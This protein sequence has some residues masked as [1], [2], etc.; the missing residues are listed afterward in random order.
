MNSILKTLSIVTILFIYCVP[1][2][3][4]EEP[5]PYTSNTGIYSD[6]EKVGYSRISIKE[7][8]GLTLVRESTELNIKLLDK[9]QRVKTEAEYILSGYAL[10][11]FKFTMSSDAGDLSAVGIADKGELRIKIKSLSGVTDITLPTE[12]EFTIFALLPRWLADRPMSVGGEYTVPLFDPAAALMGIEAGDLVSTHK[13]AARETVEIPALGSVDTYRV[14]SSFL[15]SRYTSWITP[16]GEVIKQT[17]PPGLTAFKEAGED[18]GGGKYASFDIMRKTSIPSEVKLDNPRGLKYLKAE[19][20]VRGERDHGLTDLSDGYRQYSKDD[21]V[22]IKP[23]DLDDINSYTLPYEDDLFSEYISPTY[24]IQS[25]D[26]LIKKKAGDIVKGETD[27]IKA[28]SRINTWVYKN[29]KKE[30]TVSLPNA[31]DVLQSRAGD[32]NEHAAL[33]AALA[34]ASGIPT[35]LAVGTIYIDGRFYYHAWNEVFVGQWIA[36]DPTYG[37]MPADATH[38]K[39][40]EGDLKN[41]KDIMKLV[42]KLNIKVLDAS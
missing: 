14:E 31:R 13:V 12:E 4:G 6:G 29:L 8:D 19:V 24:L 40:I 11:S 16:E 1:A 30:G 28:A 26:A 25:G 34:R 37:Q 5:A 9:T 15:G 3:I 18:A 33:F 39:L 7:S 17:L 42:G 41:S 20:T 38:I 35:K 22:E 23:P 21:I 2:S 32:C 27:P 10:A 36:V